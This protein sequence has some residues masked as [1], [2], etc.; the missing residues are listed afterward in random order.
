[1][2]YGFGGGFEPGMLSDSGLE[3]GK[4]LTFD[5]ALLPHAGD[6]RQAGV[7]RDGLEFNHPLLA[8]TTALHP[9]VLP[10]RWGFLD[11]APPNVVVS[12]LKP[13]PD[14]AA[15]LRV[16]EAE[17]RPT[18]AKIR[19]TAQLVTAE[20]VNLMEDPGGKLAVADNTLHLDFRPFEIK[21][22]KLQLQSWLGR[23]TKGSTT[24]SSAPTPSAQTR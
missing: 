8:G 23:P 17:G 5:Y 14:G 15:V 21:T 2:A 9:G 20:E 7:Y 3:L 1:V 11:I 10:K 24:V 12:A 6:W 22:I 13:G 16:Y 18:R 4:E 19:L